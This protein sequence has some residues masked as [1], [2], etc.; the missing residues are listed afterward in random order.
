MQFRTEMANMLP[1]SR[2]DTPRFCWGGVR[3]GRIAGRPKWIAASK[4]QKK[5]KCKLVENARK[6]DKVLWK[7]SCKKNCQW[8]GTNPI[9]LSSGRQSAAG[10]LD[11][12]HIRGISEAETVFKVYVKRLV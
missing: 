7:V 4:K 11:T 8:A 6:F 10:A 2:H 3:G 12:A 1:V 5:K 9:K